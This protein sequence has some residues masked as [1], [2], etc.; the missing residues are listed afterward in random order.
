[1]SEIALVTYLESPGITPDD[2]L[3]ADALEARGATVHAAP[4]DAPRDWSAFALVLLRSPWDYYLRAAE[5]N[6]WVDDLEMTGVRLVNPYEVVRWNGDKRYLLELERRGITGVPTALIEPG[7]AAPDSLAALL[8]DRGWDEA[9]VKPVVS[10]A[11]HHTW[12]TSRATASA[13]EARFAQLRQQAA[14]GI[15]VQPFMPEIVAEGEWSL[16]FFDGRYSHAAIKRPKSGSFLVQHVHGGVYAPATPDPAIVA[17]AEQVVAAAAGCVGLEPDD[18]AYA[19]VDGVVRGE[20]RD[21]RLVL[22][23]LEC[24]EPS[25]F[26]LQAPAAAERFASSLVERALA[27]APRASYLR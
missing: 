18:L 12:R 8:A 7:D 19:R 13:D 17:Q 10:A 4:W 11:G 20:G 3:L 27:N 6:H 25:L 2:Q 5:F 21:A 1:M 9:V 26:F 23:E 22:M 24:L 14:G 15:F 16:I